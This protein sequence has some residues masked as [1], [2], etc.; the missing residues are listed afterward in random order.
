[1]SSIKKMYFPI[2]TIFNEMIS[3]KITKHG[4]NGFIH[5]SSTDTSGQCFVKVNF[6]SPVQ[7]IERDPNNVSI[8][9]SPNS[10]FG[11]LRD[12]VISGKGMVLL[13]AN[14]LSFQEF[15]NSYLA[16]DYLEIQELNSGLIKL[17]KH[18]SNN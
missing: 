16:S 8:T 1:M 10:I 15:G 11:E 9:F 13:K 5:N 18:L 3:F 2:N 14:K 12:F 17:T 4:Y 6:Q 7:T